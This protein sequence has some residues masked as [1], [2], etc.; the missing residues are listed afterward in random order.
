M[1]YNPSAG[2]GAPEVQTLATL[3]TDLGL[4]GTNSGDQTITLTG[5]VT[6]TGTGSFAATI[7]GGAVTLAKMANLA[8]NSIIGNNTGAGATPIA[9]TTTQ[10]KALLAIA[11]TDVSGLG[12]ISTQNAN[13]VAVTG[14]TVNGTTVGATTPATG[15]F[16]TLGWTGVKYTAS[17]S[18]QGAAITDYFTSTISLDAASVYEIDAVA[19]F[20]KTTAGTVVWTWAF[21]SAPNVA[22]SFYN[23]TPITGFTT[24]V[25]TGA[26]VNAQAAIKSSATLVHAASGS[27]S[28][29][30]S[31]VFRFRML[32]FTNLATTIQLR[33]TQ[34]AGTLTPNAGSFM[35]ASKVL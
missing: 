12:T 20:L 15:A 1:T 24:T 27:L 13:A 4:T 32:V 10:T 7:A 17:G 16:T 25:V 9:L 29:G 34:S 3:K 6:G 31:H 2:T 22:Q 23:E 14:G 21:S 11:N 26:P 8:A 19:Y 30:V 18:A 35:R 33:S 28:T 5:D